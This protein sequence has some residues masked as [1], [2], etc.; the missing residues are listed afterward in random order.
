MSGTNCFKC[1]EDREPAGYIC[2]SCLDEVEGKSSTSL[3]A[4]RE[5]IIALLDGEVGEVLEQDRG[6]IKV[7]WDGAHFMFRHLGDRFWQIRPGDKGFNDLFREGEEKT[8]PL[9]T[10]ECIAWAASNE[11]RGWVVSRKYIGNDFWEDWVVPQ[12][13][14]YDGKE[15][16]GDPGVVSYRR[17]RVLPDNSGIDE[18]TIQGFL[19]EVV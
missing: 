14:K 19:V 5:A 11:S 9:D 13:F 16:Y 7:K 15:E 17:A 18:S 8:R 4:P 10:F 2:Q 6:L 12:W 1:G 3:L